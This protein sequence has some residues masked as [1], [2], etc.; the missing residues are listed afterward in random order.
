MK[1]KALF[2]IFKGFQLPKIVFKSFGNQI[3]YALRFGQSG[4][5]L[6]QDFATRINAF[7]LLRKLSEPIVWCIE[8]TITVPDFCA[9]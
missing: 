9:H 8:S 5:N 2:I 4:I 1:W 6:S 3:L 7:I